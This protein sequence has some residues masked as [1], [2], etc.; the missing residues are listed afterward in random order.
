VKVERSVD[1]LGGRYDGLRN[2]LTSKDAYQTRITNPLG[3]T[4]YTLAAHL[5]LHEEAAS[6]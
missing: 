5:S 3:G 6:P 4:V 1:G 2:D